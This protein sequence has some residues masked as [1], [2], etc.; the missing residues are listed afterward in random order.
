M[1]TFPSTPPLTSTVAAT[2]LDTLTA[3]PW[4]VVYVETLGEEPIPVS[5]G[6]Y[7]LKLKDGRRQPRFP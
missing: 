3:L 1:A 7:W 6:R 5:A 4:R 2:R